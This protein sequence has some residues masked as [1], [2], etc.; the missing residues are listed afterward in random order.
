[1]TLLVEGKFNVN[2]HAHL[3]QGNDISITEWFFY[4]F[5][6]R[7]LTRYLTRQGAGRYK[8]TKN[9]LSKILVP[10][11]SL[12]E[13]RKITEIL[14]IN[15]VIISKINQLISN[16]EIRNKALKQQL[17][18][19]Y[20]RTMHILMSE[21][22]KPVLKVVGSNT[23]KFELLS[24]TKNGIVSQKEYFNKEVASEDL[25]NYKIVIKG[26][27][28]MSGLN[29]WMGSIDLM[30]DFDVGIVSPA[31]KVFEVNTNKICIRYFKHFVKSKDM[32]R[33]LVSCSIVGASIVRR[34]FDKEMF[35]NWLLKLPLLKDQK[36]IADILDCTANE[37]KLQQQKLK[38]MKK[39]KMG[40][41]RKLLTGEV[42]IKI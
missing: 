15:D 1:M 21:V 32:L 20:P 40:L 11:P 8:L 24:V 35:D 38:I 34:N 17:E 41:M 4:Y 13:Q 29:F 25:T 37:L 16:L 12:N 5:N 6:H 39:Q 7:E 3:I 22:L 31:Y 33:I 10:L 42:R 30:T 27:V 9:S 2:N 26:E 19:K 14:S 36:I 28:V 18:K 23:D